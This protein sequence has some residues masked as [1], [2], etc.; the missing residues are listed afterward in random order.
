MQP[1]AHPP[2]QLPV[3]CV[4]L[5]QPTAPAG[6]MQ[7]NILTQAIKAELGARYH[8]THVASLER[9]APVEDIPRRRGAP[10]GL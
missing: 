3:E 8:G 1:G 6:G 4:L 2:L 9:A 10:A 5:E 7:R